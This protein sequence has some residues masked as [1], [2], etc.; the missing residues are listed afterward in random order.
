MEKV[1]FTVHLK[2]NEEDYHYQGKGLLKNGILHYFEGPVKVSISMKEP[3]YLK[4]EQEEY[5]LELYFSKGELKQGT[6]YLKQWKK[7]I[8]LET[9]TKNI[10]KGVGR[11]EI[12]YELLLDQEPVQYQFLLEYEVQE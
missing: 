4:R 7:N 2:G 10:D 6:Y 9:K 11:M 5:L 1:K 8:P 3:I 12:D